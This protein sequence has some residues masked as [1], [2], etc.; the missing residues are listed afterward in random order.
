M[1]DNRG[2]GPVKS[3]DIPGLSRLRRHVL[4]GTAGQWQPAERHCPRA[5]SRLDPQ[6]QRRRFIGWMQ[7]VAQVSAGEMGVIDGET[8]RRSLA[9]LED[10][11]GLARSGWLPSAPDHGNLEYICRMR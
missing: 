9:Y 3:A 6:A 2:A 8:A 10:P 1:P 7:A 5:L 4:S 11:S